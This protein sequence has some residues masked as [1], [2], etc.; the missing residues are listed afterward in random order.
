MQSSLIA[1]HLPFPKPAVRY[2]LILYNLDLYFIEELKHQSM[3]FVFEFSRN[4]HE[5]PDIGLF[6]PLSPEL[7]KGSK[8]R[9]L[10]KFCSSI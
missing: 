10:D 5:L 6:G 3:S 2:I 4:R 8:V 9:S 7:P 1:I